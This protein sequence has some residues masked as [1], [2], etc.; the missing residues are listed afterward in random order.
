[1]TIFIN[2]ISDQI[3]TDPNYEDIYNYRSSYDYDYL[4]Q[5]N[6]YALFRE[7]GIENI[8]ETRSYQ[9]G[10]LTMMLFSKAIQKNETAFNYVMSLLDKEGSYT[11]SEIHDLKNILKNDQQIKDYFT[12][13]DSENVF[14]TLGKALM[15]GII[16]LTVIE[17]APVVVAYIQYSKVALFNYFIT[18]YDSI[19]S[20]NIGNNPAYQLAANNGI[21]VG[22]LAIPSSLALEGSVVLGLEV[23]HV[24][25]VSAETLSNVL[26][27]SIE[28]V[29]TAAQTMAGSGGSGDYNPISKIHRMSEQELID[30]GK[31]DTLID[32]AIAQGVKS[33]RQSELDMN[34]IFKKLGYEL[35][36]SFKGTTPVSYGSAGSVRPDLYNKD[37]K[38]AIEVKNYNIELASRRTS[39]KNI[40][41]TQYDKRVS[42]LPMGA[43]Q[44]VIIDFRGR[45][46]T[47]QILRDLSG[48]IKAECS[49]SI[50]ILFYNGIDFLKY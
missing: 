24:S 44:T 41:L 18:A 47:T 7:S 37:T 33:W 6:Q 15:V 1:M 45:N 12:Q 8:A 34:K 32:D 4:W 50:E 26:Y 42:N 48:G 5:E 39:L 3:P 49:G 28:E 31:T 17:L 20:N 25:S 36:Q 40:I 10:L 2:E 46:V 43:S 27:A 30:E 21:T 19:L 35:Q 14:D 22:G 11:R 16:V 29:L 13:W 38:H 9:K 23:T